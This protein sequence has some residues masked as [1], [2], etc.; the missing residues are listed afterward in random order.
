[1][2]FQLLKRIA[3]Y[4]FC[5]LTMFP[6]FLKYRTDRPNYDITQIASSDVITV[7]NANIRG[8]DQDDKGDTHWFVRAPLLVK[9]L[10][11]A[12]PD[13]LAM[14]EVSK[15]QYDYLKKALKGYGNEIMYPDEGAFAGGVA[16]FYNTAKFSLVKTGSFW[17]SET[18]EQRSLGWDADCIRGCVFMVLQQKSDGKS[19]AVFGTHLDH[20]GSEARVKGIELIAERMGEFGDLPCILTGDLNFGAEYGKAYRTA[21][22]YFKDAKYCAADSDDGTT[23]HGWE[24]TDYVEIDD[25]FF[26][27]K[28]GIDVQQYRILRD[29]YDGVYPSDHYPIMMKMTLSD[30]AAPEDEAPAVVPVEPIIIPRDPFVP[31]V[32]VTA[33]TA[34]S[35][36]TE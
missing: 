15:V 34:A 6:A 30:T 36:G 3:I 7:V 13:V 9:T 28:A 32:P 8:F 35:A 31:S 5:V 33:P 12:A 21:T 23:W 29:S 16:L 27:S 1:M 4:L 26:I 20:K 14:E 17:V 19:F 25:Y 24:I 2:F 11:K 18:P 10:R 22:A